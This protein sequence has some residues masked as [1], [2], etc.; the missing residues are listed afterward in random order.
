MVGPLQAI[1]PRLEAP[2]RFSTATAPVA[3]LPMLSRHIP[4]YYYA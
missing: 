3:S 4:R 2:Y 1:G